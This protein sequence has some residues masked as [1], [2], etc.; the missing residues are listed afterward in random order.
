MSL[1]FP[2]LSLCQLLLTGTFLLLNLCHVCSLRATSSALRGMAAT[3][4]VLNLE[5]L[6][7]WP[8]PPPSPPTLPPYPPPNRLLNASTHLECNFET[9]I[10]MAIAS[11]QAVHGA[12]HRTDSQMQC[13]ALCAMK[14]SC[15]NFVYI[16]DTRVCV[17]LPPVTSEQLIRVKN[18]GT[19]G[20][21]VFVSHVNTQERTA[22]HAQCNYDV[23]RSYSQGLL[24]SATAFNGENQRITSQQVNSF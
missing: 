11:E 9:G 13:C 17:L 24:G 19:V 21:T 10:D 5:E 22:A 16:P 6:P 15:K 2:F 12:Q 7:T 1:L 18:P 23:G 14:R 4:S 3:V 8:L 20:G